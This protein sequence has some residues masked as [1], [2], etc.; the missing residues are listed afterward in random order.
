MGRT[1]KE[2]AAAE[3]ATA[4]SKVRGGH[5]PSVVKLCL[6]KFRQSITLGYML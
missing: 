3:V 5:S 6:L 2:A 4:Q 1:L